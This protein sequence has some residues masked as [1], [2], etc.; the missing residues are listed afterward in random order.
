MLPAKDPL[1]GLHDDFWA[2]GLGYGEGGPRLGALELQIRILQGRQEYDRGVSKVRVGPQASAGV[3]AAHLGHQNVQE[4]EV[5]PFP[6][7]ESDSGGAISGDEGLEAGSIKG[8][9]QYPEDELVVIDT[10]DCGRPDRTCSSFHLIGLHRVP[11]STAPELDPVS[12]MY[13]PQRLD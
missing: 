10:E 1:D 8:V 7:G 9:T 11:T 5:R 13:L 4:N 3:E 12:F 2:Q 6:P